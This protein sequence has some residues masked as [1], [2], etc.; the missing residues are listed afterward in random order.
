MNKRNSILIIGLSVFLIITAVLVYR[1][2]VLQPQNYEQPSSEDSEALNVSEDGVSSDGHEEQPVAPPPLASGKQ[3]Y[4]I[5]TDNPKN[6]QILEV[7]VD[8][9]DVQIGQEQTI[10]VTIQNDETET[11]TEHDSVVATIVTDT[12]SAEIPLKLVKAEGEDA[13]LSYWKGVWERDDNYEIIYELK[14]KAKDIKG[15][16]TVVITFR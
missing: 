15:E 13:L 14:I 12:K 10:I 1:M 7:E 11:I 6:P 3:T 5:Y 2:V 9:L 4:A 16:N 8:P